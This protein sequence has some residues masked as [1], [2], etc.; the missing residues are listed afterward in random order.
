MLGLWKRKWKLPYYILSGHTIAQ[1][2]S[3]PEKGGL[4]AQGIPNTN[5]NAGAL[6]NDSR[7]LDPAPSAPAAKKGGIPKIKGTILE[8]PIIRTIIFWGLFWGPPILGKYQSPNKTCVLA[9]NDDAQHGCRQDLQLVGDLV[10][11]S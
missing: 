10:P 11:Y 2:C 8:V 5:F 1:Q 3:S 7:V 9:K 6:Q 4:R